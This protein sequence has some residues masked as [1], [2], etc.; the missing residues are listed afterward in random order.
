MANFGQPNLTFVRIRFVL[1]GDLAC[2]H[3][4][5]GRDEVHVFGA[6]FLDNEEVV[7][8]LLRGRIS[9]PNVIE[10][11]KEHGT[12]MTVP[13]YHPRGIPEIYFNPSGVLFDRY[14]RGK[15]LDFGERHGGKRPARFKEIGY[16]P[17]P[18][19]RKANGGD[20]GSDG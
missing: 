4:P 2:F 18:A 12:N 7:L 9:G 6:K 15:V 10:N 14:F 5:E 16:T 19:T 3:V 11:T 17:K 1:V 8:E 20:K 13:V